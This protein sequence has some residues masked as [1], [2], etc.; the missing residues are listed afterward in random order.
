M[1][2]WASRM[3]GDEPGESMNPTPHALQR[4]A[5]RFPG[6]DLKLEWTSA[7]RSRSVGKRLFNLLRQSCPENAPRFMS[8]RTFKGVYYKVS[9][10][11]VVFVVKPPLVIVTV[12]RAP[13]GF[14]TEQSWVLVPGTTQYCVRNKKLKSTQLQELLEAGNALY[15]RFNGVY[16][17]QGEEA[18]ALKRRWLNAIK[19]EQS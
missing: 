14:K 17:N 18:E 5:E 13:E 8:D 15:V 12:L 16:C 10:H 19:P 3:P 1:S 9:K 4:F 7:I 6:L 2:R 11:G